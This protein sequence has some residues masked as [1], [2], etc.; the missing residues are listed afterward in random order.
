MT[1]E[2]Y[3]TMWEG[4]KEKLTDTAKEKGGKR[5]AVTDA[6]IAEVILMAMEAWEKHCSSTEVTK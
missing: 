1:S 3:K 5:T 2:S 6:E 4:L